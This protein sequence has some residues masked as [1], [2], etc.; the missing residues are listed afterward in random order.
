LAVQNTEAGYKFVVELKDAFDII[1]EVIVI[2][3]FEDA[4]YQFL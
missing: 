3:I 4:K 1:K 2:P